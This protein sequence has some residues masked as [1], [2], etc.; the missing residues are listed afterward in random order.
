MASDFLR[1]WVRAP[2]IDAAFERAGRTPA[3][4][5]ALNWLCRPRGIYYSW[6]EAVKAAA[7]VAASGHRYAGYDHPDL[8]DFHSSLSGK[9]RASDHAALFWISRA[10]KCGRL[11]ILDIGGCVGNLYHSYRPFLDADLDVEWTVFDLPAVCDAGRRIAA[12][13]G[14]N[15]ELR[16]ITELHEAGDPNLV[17]ISG[18]LHYWPRPVQQLLPLIHGQPSWIVV[19]RTPMR[20][21][22]DPGFFAVQDTG[23]CCVPA[24]VFQSEQLAAEFDK[25]GYKTVDAW[26]CPELSFFFP[27]FRTPY[28]GF[29]CR[30]LADSA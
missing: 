21:G 30:R 8:I 28:A 20:S 11:R 7:D 4:V 3:G 16:F 14:A 10:A 29:C 9:M 12:E 15:R 22:G 6:E 2:F 23:T 17:L 24:A 5:H 18:A 25:A 19:N 27:G 1:W 13:R 26:E